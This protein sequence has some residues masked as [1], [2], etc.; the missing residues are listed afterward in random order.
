M[1]RR[2]TILFFTWAAGGVDAIVYMMAHV[3]T[4][5][6]TGNAV[7]LGLSLA[8]ELSMATVHSLVA[9]V[10]FAVG[11]MLSA[12]LVGEK[13][14][15]IPWKGVRIAVVSE[16]VVLALFAAVFF[17]PFPHTSEPSLEAM[18]SLSGL[19]MGMQSATVTRLNMPGIATT[20][21]TGTM[22]SLISGL[23][24]HWGAEEEESEQEE[25][26]EERSIAL[27]AWVFVLYATAAFTSGLVY[28][29][30]PSGVAPLPLIAI[31]V[32][33]VTLYGHHPPKK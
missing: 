8:R 14:H 20:Y 25:L 10:A 4:A 6:M 13:G 23:V 15:G 17:L 21:I 33:T 31:I 3:F 11:V 29:H 18:I 32:V 22:T 24:H 27:Q 7:L 19:A 30:W 16:S 12:F 2:R 28:R 9:L 5:N 26:K 1:P